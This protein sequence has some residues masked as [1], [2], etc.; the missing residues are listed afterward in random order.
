MG[1]LVALIYSVVLVMLSN[2]QDNVEN[3]FDNMGLD[4]I[5]LDK[6]NRI[7]ELK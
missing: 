7:K 1:Y 2:I 4:D 6:E 3:P 5:D